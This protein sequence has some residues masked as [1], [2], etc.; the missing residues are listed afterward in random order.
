MSD[1][2]TVVVK[3]VEETDSLTEGAII[4]LKDGQDVATLTVHSSRFYIHRPPVTNQ[5]VE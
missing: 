3:Q 2:I 1:C 5:N 4:D